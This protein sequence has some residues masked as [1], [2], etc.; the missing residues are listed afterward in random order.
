MFPMWALREFDRLAIVFRAGLQ[1]RT[2]A[3]QCETMRVSL[4]TRPS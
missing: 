2:N 4:A 3:F 1:A